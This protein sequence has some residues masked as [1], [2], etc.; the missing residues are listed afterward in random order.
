MKSNILRTICLLHLLLL[1]LNPFVMA[2]TEKVLDS[3]KVAQMERWKESPHSLFA[4][5]GTLLAAEAHKIYTKMALNASFIYQYDIPWQHKRTNF[6]VTSGIGYNGCRRDDKSYRAK[7]DMVY[8]EYIYDN[9]HFY[10]GAGLKVR[11]AY[12]LD[13][14]FSAAIDGALSYELGRY[15]S[16]YWNKRYPLYDETDGSYRLDRNPNIGYG[17]RGLF[18]IALTYE[19]KNFRILAGYQA[20]V[21]YLEREYNWY[22]PVPKAMPFNSWVIFGFGYRFGKSFKN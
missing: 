18:S 17:V 22:D 7:N 16:F 3:T 9:L 19:I 6:F 14:S 8:E 1:G 5:C 2:K 20:Y 12:F 21:G 4:S 15:P 11:L 10:V 13:L